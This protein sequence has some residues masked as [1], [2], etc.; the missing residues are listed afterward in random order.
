M[1]SGINMRLFHVF[2]SQR[3]QPC[4]ICCL[5]TVSSCFNFFS[6]FHRACGRKISLIPSITSW[7][8]LEASNN[9]DFTDRFT[10]TYKLHM[11]YPVEFTQA[12]SV[13]ILTRA[14]TLSLFSDLPVLHFT[15][16]QSI[17]VLVVGASC[18]CAWYVP[19]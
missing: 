1:F 13:R 19:Y 2:F 4:C 7:P 10:G 8:E 18:Y 17:A 5:M 6:R 15:L 16:Y 3:L 14:L 9:P 11:F 12:V